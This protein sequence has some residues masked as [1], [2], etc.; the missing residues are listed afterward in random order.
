M[1]RLKETETPKKFELTF[2]DTS[3]LVSYIGKIKNPETDDYIL[4]LYKRGV[5]FRR[6]RRVGIVDISEER[7]INYRQIL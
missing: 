1:P 3:D 6:L 7:V 2:E 5:I 4:T